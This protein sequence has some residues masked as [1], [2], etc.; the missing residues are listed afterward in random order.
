M[1]IDELENA[2]AAPLNFVLERRHSRN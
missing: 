2:L 1:F